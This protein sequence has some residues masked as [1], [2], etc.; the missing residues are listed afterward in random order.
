LGVKI[1][2]QSWPGKVKTTTDIDNHGNKI[3]QWP[4]RCILSIAGTV[5]GEMEALREL[6]E[7][8]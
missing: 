3:D 4:A 7:W 8:R 2:G 1:D 6:D 5:Y